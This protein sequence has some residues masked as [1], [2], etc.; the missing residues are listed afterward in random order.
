[1]MTFIKTVCIVAFAFLF[2]VMVR[3]LAFADHPHPLVGD[4]VFNKADDCPFVEG[5]DS[6]G[7]EKF[8]ADCSKVDHDRVEI[9]ALATA[10]PNLYIKDS[11]DV[12]F[13]MALGGSQDGAAVGF[14]ASVNLWD[15]GADF[16][17]AGAVEQHGEWMGKAQVSWGFN[18]TK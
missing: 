4:G 11:D 14:G 5:V 13:H 10:I 9:N 1:M 12:R 6:E 15:G 2:L 3:T 7:D 17:I 16:H 18:F 8:F